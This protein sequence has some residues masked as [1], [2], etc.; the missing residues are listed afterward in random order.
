ML[1]GI[2]TGPG[3]ACCHQQLATLP[4]Q[5]NKRLCVVLSCQPSKAATC[6]LV[7]ASL[8]HGH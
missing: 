2:I 1:L 4:R 3:F 5:T 7:E 6:L 8:G